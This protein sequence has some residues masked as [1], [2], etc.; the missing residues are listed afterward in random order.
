MPRLRKTVEGLRRRCPTG[1]K[2]APNLASF[3]AAFCS[4]CTRAKNFVQAR[5]EFYSL[6][7]SLFPLVLLSSKDL[8][9]HAPILRP[10]SVSRQDGLSLIAFPDFLQRNI[11][12]PSPPRISTAQPWQSC[13]PVHK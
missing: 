7:P 8:M 11:S 4:L 12:P 1:V 5:F 3:D 13:A 9:D 2:G 10:Q 6:P